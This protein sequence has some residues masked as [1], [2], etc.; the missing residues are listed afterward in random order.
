M[1]LESINVE[2]WDVENKAIHSLG[3]LRPPLCKD[4]LTKREKLRKVC[5]R[6]Y[7]CCWWWLSN[8]ECT[9]NAGDMGSIPGS[10]R[11][12]GEGNGNP[13]HYSCLENAMDGG[14]RRATVH[15][16]A[17][18]VQMTEVTEY[19][20]AADMEMQLHA[21]VTLFCKVEAGRE[22]CFQSES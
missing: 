5:F 2:M 17:K 18:T 21:Y 8:K 22:N 16:V 7:S 3:L 15:W 12:P 9:P 4:N 13:L 10:G 14:A 11:S 1:R 20:H 19:T 6:A